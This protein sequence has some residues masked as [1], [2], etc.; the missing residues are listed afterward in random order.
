[1]NTK[2][3]RL[4]SLIYIAL[5]AAVITICAQIQI[6]STVPFTLQ[7]FGV[8]VAAGLL[9]FKRGTLS[10]V[11]YILLGLIGLP[12]F[13]GFKGGPAVLFGTTGGYIIGFIF[14]AVI[15]G[16]FKDKFGVV[17]WSLALSMTLG[18]LVCYIFGTVWFYVITNSNSQMSVFTI[19]SLCVFPY[20]PFDVLK[21][22]GAVVFVNRIE[23]IAN[24]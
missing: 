3:S 14:I 10:V 5:F 8:F 1:M 19:L 20:I 22:I 16:L 12:V 18:L 9:G 21:I 15:V 4:L 11:I 23:K 6:P 2:N 7:T 13:S 17:L 24:I